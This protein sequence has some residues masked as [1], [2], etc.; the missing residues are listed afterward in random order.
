MGES[1]KAMMGTHSR[2]T[3]VYEGESI[4]VLQFLY[5]RTS[6]MT[7]CLQPFARLVSQVSR[8]LRTEFY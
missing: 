7:P 5:E 8:I 6:L 2:H 4:I 1:T 3:C